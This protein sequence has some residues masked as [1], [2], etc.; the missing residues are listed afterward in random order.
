MTKRDLFLKALHCQNAGPP[1]IWL[2]R[3]AGRYMPDY[4]ALRSKYSL[5]EMFHHP[6]LIV[7]VTRLPLNLLDVDAAILF[8]D[9]LIVL[10]A[11][12][13]PWH[14]EEGI[15]PILPKTPPHPSSLCHKKA[16]ETYPQIYQA[17]KTLKEGIE[18]PLIGF[19][20]APFTVASYL[21]EGKTSRDL[22]KTKQW[23]FQDASSFHQLLQ[24]IADATIDYLNLQID[25]GVD[26]IQLFDSW[27]HVLNQ[28]HF[29]EFSLCY[30]KKILDGVK[31]P[32]IPMIL[33]CRGSCFFLQDL[34]QLKPTGI[35]VDWSGELSSLRQQIPKGIALQGNLDPVLLLSSRAVIRSEAKH[36][37][38]SMKEF[39]G[40][41][42]NLGH[43]ILPE[44]PF[45]NVKFLVDY[46]HD[47]A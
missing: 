43:G 16:I 36:L 17:I 41:I 40:Y 33:F 34:A 13:I 21:I 38:A 26:V 44:T 24:K 46:V 31:N 47:Y 20:G 8:S 25:A 4:K 9:I 2:M 3:Q 28:R 15:G 22:Q 19:A 30:M 42:F 7:E 10:D 37:L 39:P 12:E 27:A 23:M 6:E 14:F 32:S 1:P 29:Q 45:E 35:S 11:F 18:V 5:I